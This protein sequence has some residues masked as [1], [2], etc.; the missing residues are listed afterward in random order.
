LDE[1]RARVGFWLVILA[2]GWLLSLGAGSIPL[3]DPD[4]SRFART[5]VEMARS[6]DLVVPHFE[7]Q[8]RLVKPPLLHWIQATLFRMFGPSERLAR[9][10]AAAATLLSMLILGWVSLRRFGLE[11]A[12]W[13]AAIFGTMPLVVALGKIGTLDA[14]LAVH[15]LAVVALDIA[16]PDETGSHIGLAIGFLLGLAFLTKGPV[17]V[18]VPLLIML[19]GRTAAAREILPR[20]RAAMEA[21]AGWCVVVLPWVLAFITR[22]GFDRA[23][24]VVRGEA[25]ERFFVG[26]DHLEPPWFFLAVLAVGVFPWIGPLLVALARVVI[27]R[28]DPASRTAAYAG[29]GLVAGLFFFSLSKSKLAN[30]ILPLPPLAAILLTWELGQELKSPRERIVG[31]LLLTAS[32]GAAGLGLLLASGLGLDPRFAG[33][34]P[35]GGSIYGFGAV[36]GFIGLLLRRPRWVWGGAAASSAAFLAAAFLLLVPQIAQT[37][38]SA[39]LIDEVPALRDDSRSVVAVDMKVPSLTYYLDR[40]PETVD[41]KDFRDRLDRPDAPLFVMDEDDLAA[42]PP[43]IVG[44]MK[45]VARQGKYVVLEKNPIRGAPS[46]LDGPQR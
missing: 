31:P 34:A 18:V 27:Q 11:G 21:A 10:P 17:G 9:L 7:D 43:G 45:E 15:V 13:T 12:L 19:A 37:R 28:N 38:T 1:R 33:F 36:A 16:E 42:L 39:Y 24:G 44:S 41:M 46:P 8:P 6:G 14:L 5:S 35:M 20:P 40:V 22:L 23:Y 29:A 2:G 25:L 3:L 32:L 30:Y 4:E 26:T